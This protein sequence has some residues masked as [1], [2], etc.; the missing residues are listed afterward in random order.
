VLE[1]T[2]NIGY[3]SIFDTDDL[4]TIQQKIRTLYPDLYLISAGEA[5]TTL[6]PSLAP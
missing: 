6:P 2:I 5:P 4:I 1:N 3:P